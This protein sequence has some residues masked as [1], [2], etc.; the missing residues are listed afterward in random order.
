M[1]NMNDPLKCSKMPNMDKVLF[2]FLFCFPVLGMSPGPSCMLGKHSTSELHLQ[3][4]ST[5]LRLIQISCNE[6]IQEQLNNM[7]TTVDVHIVG[8]K[9]H[10]TGYT[11]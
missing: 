9:M 7:H 8:T 5:G 11:Q 10:M 2:L 3:P 6:P 1:N 4:Q